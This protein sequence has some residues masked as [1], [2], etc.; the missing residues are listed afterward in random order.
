MEIDKRKEEVRQLSAEI[1]KLDNERVD[2]T[3]NVAVI[4]KA[5]TKLDNFTGNTTNSSV[6]LPRTLKN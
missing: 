6:I 4:D 3:R 5:T 2:L 1:F